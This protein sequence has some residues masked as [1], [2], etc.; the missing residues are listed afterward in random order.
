M[1]GV[2]GHHLPAFRLIYKTAQ[3]VQNYCDKFFSLMSVKVG[4]KAQSICNYYCYQY[5]N[6]E[7]G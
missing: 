5:F 4:K 6:F 7:F 3:R 2:S 1:F